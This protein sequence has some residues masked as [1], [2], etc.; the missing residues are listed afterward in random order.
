M[1]IDL[2]KNYNNKEEKTAINKKT[3]ETMNHIKNNKTIVTLARDP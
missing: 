3:K 2:H 1:C